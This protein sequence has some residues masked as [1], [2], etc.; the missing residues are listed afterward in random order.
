MSVNLVIVLTFIIVMTVLLWIMNDKQAKRV[1]NSWGKL[2][3]V[4]PISKII[5]SFIN[6][7]KKN[8]SNNEEDRDQ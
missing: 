2:L 4:L 7:N 1:T 6:S 3:K 5:S 8:N